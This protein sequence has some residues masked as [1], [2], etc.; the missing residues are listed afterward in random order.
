MRIDGDFNVQI[1]NH[2]KRLVVS[3]NFNESLPRKA[4]NIAE[5]FNRSNT[6]CTAGASIA[7]LKFHSK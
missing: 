5:S 4:A 1:G 3:G 7:L 6:N 2:P